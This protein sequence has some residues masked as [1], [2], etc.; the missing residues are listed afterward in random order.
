MIQD[1]T[2]RYGM[3]SIC[4]I[5]QKKVAWKARSPAN[6]S[7]HT[8]VTQFTVRKQYAD[9]FGS[10]SG[11]LR[12]CFDSA[13]DVLRD[14]FDC[15]SA[16]CRSTVE[17]QSK[18]CRRYPEHVSKACRTT[19]ERLSKKCRPFDV[20][21]QPKSSLVAYF[22]PVALLSLRDSNSDVFLISGERAARIAQSDNTSRAIYRV[23]PLLRSP[24]TAVYYLS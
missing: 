2:T 11:I 12:D 15:A 14:R 20:L 3:L 10:A 23:Y 9:F 7:C 16:S 21:C 24:R 1:D 5:S 4:V 8:V 19:V 13:S 22:L 17:Q 18:G 6:P